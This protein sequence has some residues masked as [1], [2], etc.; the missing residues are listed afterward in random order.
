MFRYEGYSAIGLCDVS[1]GGL[2][3]W[4]EVIAGQTY[5]PE[6]GP[7]AKVHVWIDGVV[8]GRGLIRRGMGVG[9]KIVNGL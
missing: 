8:D 6:G 9:K 2:R 5:C 4:G 3:T 1:D 7:G